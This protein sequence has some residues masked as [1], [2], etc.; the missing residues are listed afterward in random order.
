LVFGI[1]IIAAGLAWIISGGISGPAQ[2]NVPQTPATTTAPVSVQVTTTPTPVTMVPA[3]SAVTAVPTV[4]TTRLT[5]TAALFSADDVRNHF[6]DVTY[7]S[8][9]RLEHLNYSAGKSRVIISAVSADDDD[10]ALIEKTAKDFNDA[11]PTIKLSENIKETGTGDLFIKF[12]PQD[13]LSAVNLFEAPE[14]GPFPEDLTRRELYQGSIPAAK[15]VRG[16][17]YINAN[18]KGDARRHVVVRSLMYEMGL[19]GDTTKFTDSVFYAGENTNVD[20]SPVDKKVIAML[21]GEGFSNGMTVE[22]IRKI[23][24]IP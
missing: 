21:Y 2:D 23:V 12:L 1:F 13:G 15:I 5:T 20:L 10:I 9:N 4:T 19:T 18:L 11:S 3:T 24:Y 7:A 6:L 8:T 14:T 22:D 16:T 17:I